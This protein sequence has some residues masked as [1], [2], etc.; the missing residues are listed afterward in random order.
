MRTFGMLLTYLSLFI[1]CGCGLFY[2]KS[3]APTFKDIPGEYSLVTYD[4]KPLPYRIDSTLS[5]R[6]DTLFLSSSGEYDEV[7]SY[8]HT[9]GDISVI[10]YEGK[11]SYDGE[12]I[13]VQFNTGGGFILEIPERG[14]LTEHDGNGTIVWQKP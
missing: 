11:Y 13:L 1:V 6:S 8:E 12:A 10:R 3:T 2:G 9:N 4:G 14:I 5:V 7:V